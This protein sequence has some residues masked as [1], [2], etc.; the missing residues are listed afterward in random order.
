MAA[1]LTVNVPPPSIAFPAVIVMVES[2]TFA[3]ACD[4][5]AARISEACCPSSKSASS[6]E[7]APSTV[8]I[9]VNIS[10]AVWSAVAPASIPSSFE[11]SADTSRPSTVPEIVILPLMSI[12]ANWSMSTLKNEPSPVSN[13]NVLFALYQVRSSTPLIAAVLA[14][15]IRPSS[16]I[17]ITGIAVAEPYCAAVTPVS[18]RAVVILIVPLPKSVRVVVPLPVTLPVSVTPT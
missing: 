7:V 2:F 15:V 11:P 5:A 4:W 18:S 10:A 3:A 17:V 9:A 14:A 12:S 1:W 6:P 13:C 16:S 8:L